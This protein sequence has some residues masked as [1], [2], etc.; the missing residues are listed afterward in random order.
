MSPKSMIA[1]ENLCE[2]NNRAAHKTSVLPSDTQPVTGTD[3]QGRPAAGQS[4]T[5]A[6]GPGEW[7]GGGGERE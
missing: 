4:V 7:A 3:V 2:V 6:G 1:A 5:T